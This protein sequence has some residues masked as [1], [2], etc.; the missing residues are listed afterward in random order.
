MCPYV[1]ILNCGTINSRIPSILN[2]TKQTPEKI[3]PRNK[4]HVEHVVVLADAV[5]H[6][7]FLLKGPAAVNKP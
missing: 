3:S 4:T 5:A 6:V 1:V 2:Q 7:F